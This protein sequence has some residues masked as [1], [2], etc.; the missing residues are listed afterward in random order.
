[1]RNI[2]AKTI[3]STV[4]GLCIKACC[5]LPDDV[6]RLL[7]LALQNEPSPV[8][9]DILSQLITNATLAST[10]SMPICQDTG[11]AVI[12]ADLGQDL[13]ITD[14]DFAEAV[15]E[16][17]RLG[18]TSGFL[19]KSVVKDPLFDRSNTTDN[20]PAVIHLRLVPGDRLSLRMAPKG[21]GSENKS[22]LAMLTPA[23]GLAGV[24]DAVL[25]AVIKAGPDACPPYIV[26][27]GIGGNMETACLCAKKA[28]MRDVA[29]ANPHPRYAALEAELLELVN[30]TGIGPQGLGGKTTALAVNVEWLP[31]HIACL[32][33]AVNINCHAARHAVA[34]L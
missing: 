21:A 23:D 26:G 24:K 8:G 13:R 15:H 22:Q 4:A 25:K 11:L 20:T 30:K 10:E 18:Y 3:T 6:A 17:V 28:C 31:T 32:P 14:G 9:K 1:M 7:D 12:F 19:R 29:I 2:S 34:V 33:V 27:V 5:Q 16:G